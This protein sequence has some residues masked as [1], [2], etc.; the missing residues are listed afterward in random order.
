MINFLGRRDGSSKLS[1]DQRWKNFYSISGGWIVSNEKF[2]ENVSALDFLKLR[3]NYGMTGS[4]EGINN[5]ERY[6]TITTGSALFGTA[7][8]TSLWI[9]GMRSSERTWETIKSHNAGLDF[10][11]LK[12]RLRGEF[13]YFVKT[14]EGMFIDVTYPSI[15]GAAAP[16]TNNG[17]FRARGWEI[18]LNWNDKIG[19]VNYSNYVMFREE[20]RYSIRC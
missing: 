11:F 17:K 1:E 7:N 14:N 2:M 10:A 9:D 15:L 19:E 12:S 8:Q 13:N 3:Y 6:A 16:K 5:Y 18:A 4:V 20:Q